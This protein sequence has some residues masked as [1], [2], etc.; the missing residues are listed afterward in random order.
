MTNKR[1][2]ELIALTIVVIRDI[3][4]RNRFQECLHFVIVLLNGSRFST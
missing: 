1:V 4:P 3:V 2:M